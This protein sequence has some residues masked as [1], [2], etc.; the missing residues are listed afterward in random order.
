MT[1]RNLTIEF[2][3][4]C[5]VKYQF[6]RSGY[7]NKISRY[8]IEHPANRVRI[9]KG[10]NVETPDFEKRSQMMAHCSF[11]GKRLPRLI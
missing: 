5:T 10:S 1:L 6:S 8:L 7:P 4:D 11:S 2:L 9:S 3:E